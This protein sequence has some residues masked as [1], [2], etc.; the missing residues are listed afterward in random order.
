M[1]LVE[2]MELVIIRFAVFCGTWCLLRVLLLISDNSSSPYVILGSI[3]FF[4]TIALWFGLS[5]QLLPLRY[6]SIP[7][8]RVPFVFCILMCSVNLNC[9]SNVTPKYFAVLVHFILALSMVRSGSSVE[10]YSM[11]CV[12]FTLTLNPLFCSVLII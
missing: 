12:L 9:W 4:S 1:L 8:A 11:H 6:F 3:K 5:P 2:Y 7:S 10:F